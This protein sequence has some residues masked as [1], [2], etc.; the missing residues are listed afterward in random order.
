M[1]IAS[2]GEVQDPCQLKTLSYNTPVIFLVSVTDEACSL[3]FSGIGHPLPSLT[4]IATF[5]ASVGESH[6]T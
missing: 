4:F 1:E 3:M 2:A 6:P 5:A